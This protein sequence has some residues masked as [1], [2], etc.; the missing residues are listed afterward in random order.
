VSVRCAAVSVFRWLLRSALH[1]S[2]VGTLGYASTLSP[3]SAVPG[4]DPDRL[5][6]TIQSPTLPMLL[7]APVLI[8]MDEVWQSNH[9]GSLSVKERGLC[10]GAKQ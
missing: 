6:L 1:C 5:G 4:P 2:S 3:A 7:M 8:G 9:H 10:S